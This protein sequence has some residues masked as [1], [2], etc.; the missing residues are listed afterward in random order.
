MSFDIVNNPT[1]PTVPY[2]VDDLA[3][4]GTDAQLIADWSQNIDSST[5]LAARD[6][7]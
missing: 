5:N 3:E 4:H 1:K 6:S 2:L 7:L